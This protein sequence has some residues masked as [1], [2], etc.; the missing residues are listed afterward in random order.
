VRTARWRLAIALT[1]GLFAVAARAELWGYID[2]QGA[3]HFATS[4]LDDRYQ[5]F[6]K[7]RSTLDPLPTDPAEERAR[8]ALARSPLFRRVV[9]H[10]NVR[11]FAP[12]I[13]QQAK[14]FALDPALI[15]AVVAV[16]SAF[17]PDAISA[18]GAVGLMQ[19]LPE[20]AERYGLA[21]D[22]RRTVEQQLLDPTINVRIGTRYLRDL[23]KHFEQDTS[24][25]LAAYNAG[26]E[27]VRQ[28]GNRIP[29]FPETREY[30]ALVQ[31]F[32]LL[33]RPKPAAPPPSARPR[34]LMPPKLPA[35]GNRVL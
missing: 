1:I 22:R 14:A 24:L 31:Q 13:D 7:G 32:H 17:V 18:K 25:A 35:D 26:E 8:A 21:A 29:P 27:S 23:L 2:E 9:D 20:T 11:R 30:V 33:Y 5:L 19:V 15:K 3:A 10:P 28:Y 16:E 6:F 34:L 12:L 4:K